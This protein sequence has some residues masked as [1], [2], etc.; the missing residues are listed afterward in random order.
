MNK[1]RIT[2]EVCCPRR[3]SWHKNTN[4]IL[5]NNQITKKVMKQL[6]KSIQSLFKSPETLPVFQ[7][8]NL[9]PP[10]FI[11]LYNG[12]P[13]SPDDFEFTTPALFIDYSI[14]WDKAGTMRLGTLTLEVHILTDPTP[15]TDN[16]TAPPQRSRK[17]RLLRN[18]FRP[19]RRSFHLRNLRSRPHLRAS[20][21]HRLLQLPCHHLHLHHF[22]PSH[23]SNRYHYRRCPITT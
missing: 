4:N 6:Y 2:A 10:E 14:S 16:L 9:C 17:S 15:E 7:Q 21:H 23:P 19:P 3:G 1:H 11:D 12:Q 20:R 5:I 13:E 18:H 22:P 8:L